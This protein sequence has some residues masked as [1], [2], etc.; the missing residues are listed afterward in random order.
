MYINANHYIDFF[1]NND[2]FARFLV[3]VHIEYFLVFH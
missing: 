3:A 2:D 1:F